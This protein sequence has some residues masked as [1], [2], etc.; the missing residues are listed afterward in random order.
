MRTRS[1]VVIPFLTSSS[2][3]GVM[4]K[5]A[6]L[7]KL[8]ATNSPTPCSIEVPKLL[9]T[10]TCTKP[11]L[12]LISRCISPRIVMRLAIQRSATVI[13]KG[14]CS[15]SSSTKVETITPD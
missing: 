7:G 5:E 1:M 10:E 6:P 13:L 14:A 3:E 12:S 4:I 9:S 2:L 11:V 15:I 8:S